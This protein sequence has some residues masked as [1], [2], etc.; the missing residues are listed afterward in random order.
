VAAEQ[1]HDLKVLGP[2]K[3]DI[4]AAKTTLQA[5]EADLV[6]ARQELANTKLRTPTHGVIQDRV[7]EPADMAWLQKLVLTL[8]LDDPV[9]VRGY[10]SEVVLGKI[11][12][13]M[14]ADVSTKS[15][16]GKRYEA[17]IGCGRPETGGVFFSCLQAG[18]PC[19]RI[20]VL[21]A[22]LPLRFFLP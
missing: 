3:E 22:L 6:F 10:V 20:L 18:R 9:W 7:Q 13:G 12:L 11:R 17:W 5:D 14:N 4:A 21:V 1:A 19:T 15:F 16:L 2:R 8:A